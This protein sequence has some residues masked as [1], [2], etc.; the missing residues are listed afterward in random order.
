LNKHRTKHLIEVIR[1]VLFEYEKYEK[2]FLQM[3][4]IELICRIL[5]K[6]HGLTENSLPKSFIHLK[7]LALKE[8]FLPDVDV[9]NTKE[10]LDGLMLLANGRVFLQ[11]MDDIKIYQL[12]DRLKI[13]PFGE[14]IQKVEVINA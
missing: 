11:A 5:V 14:T 6:E 13:R 7:G 9:T 4:I 3:N 2:D 12:F 10:L 8:K 1:N